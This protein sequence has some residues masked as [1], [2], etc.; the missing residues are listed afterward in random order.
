MLHENLQPTLYSVEYLLILIFLSIT[1]RGAF[2]LRHLSSI[3]PI[4]H[5]TNL[6]VLFLFVISFIFLFPINFAHYNCAAAMRL[7]FDDTI[8]NTYSVANEPAR[9]LPCPP[10]SST[11]HFIERNIIYKNLHGL[12][13]DF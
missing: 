6:F 4:S 3:Y 5:V 10:H 11:D 12:M 13:V 2:R 1:E 8:F 9:S 7:W